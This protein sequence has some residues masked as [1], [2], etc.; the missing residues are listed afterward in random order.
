MIYVLHRW[1]ALIALTLWCCVVS[2]PSGA[3]A[4]GAAESG[5]EGK[6]DSMP[7]PTQAASNP[8]S[9]AGTSGFFL[10][11]QHCQSCHGYLG[12]GTDNVDALLGSRYSGD[13]KY[14]KA[15]HSEFRRSSK[16]HIAVA[17]GT[18]KNPGPRFNQLELIGK[19][20]REIEA[21]HAMLSKHSADK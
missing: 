19:F 1:T 11:R 18:R 21:W 7:D 10:Y 17:R 8:L 15:F 4:A 20:L 13:H 16:D 2:A 12:A 5:A 9:D 3:F 6:A 14:R